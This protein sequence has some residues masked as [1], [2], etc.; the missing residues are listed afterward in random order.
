M[1][2]AHVIL[3]PQAFPLCLRGFEKV[4]H[5]LLH[6]PVASKIW[7]KFLGMISTQWVMPAN[8]SESLLQWN[9]YCIRKQ[10]KTI[11]AAIPHAVFWA[12][13][14]DCNH[15]KKIQN[16]EG[17]GEGV[18]GVGSS[19]DFYHIFFGFSDAILQRLMDYRMGTSLSAFIRSSCLEKIHTLYYSF[20]IH[21]FPYRRI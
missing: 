3:F 18:P 15:K 16:V 10:L 13:W 2:N 21:T 5:L 12:T 4:P 20:Y 7:N 8:V 14:K 11:W 19:L 1:K 6:C 17:G 9:A